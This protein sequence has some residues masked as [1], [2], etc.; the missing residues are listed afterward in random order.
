[1]DQE[2]RVFAIAG[3]RVLVVALLTSL[4]ASPALYAAEG[5]AIAVV[6]DRPSY[7]LVGFVGGFVR[8]TN[9]HHGPVKVARHLKQDAPKDTHIEVFEN[10]HRRSALK[11]ILRLLD[12]N[13]DGV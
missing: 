1:M 7:I 9:T 6:P 5:G 3:S 12:A 2:F 13:R 11:T 4:A 8:H 10:R